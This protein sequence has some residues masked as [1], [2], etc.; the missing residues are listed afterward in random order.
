MLADQQ[1]DDLLLVIVLHILLVE[2][3]QSFESVVY[4]TFEVSSSRA[5][6][7]CVGRASASVMFGDAVAVISPCIFEV[8]DEIVS[9]FTPMSCLHD[10]L[11]AEDAA[12]VKPTFGQDHPQNLI[13]Y[14]ALG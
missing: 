14:F 5:G 8:D 11:F 4:D 12:Q 9:R 10:R 2:S 13:P 7:V 6:D 3:T 1:I